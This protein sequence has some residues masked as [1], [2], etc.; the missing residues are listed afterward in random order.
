MWTWSSIHACR[1]LYMRTYPRT[2]MF[3]VR[4]LWG[5]REIFS[6]SESESERKRERERG[7]FANIKLPTEVL[8]TDGEEKKLKDLF[9]R[10]EDSSCSSSYHHYHLSIPTRIAALLEST[11]ERVEIR[12]WEKQRINDRR[13]RS[14]RRKR[15]ASPI[16]VAEKE[17]KNEEE[18][19]KEG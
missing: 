4:P 15:W 9:S 5:V 6:W 11:R 14:R 16:A 18:E 10:E 7:F 3:S 17:N 19:E 8:E 2:C 1:D 13:E 12:S